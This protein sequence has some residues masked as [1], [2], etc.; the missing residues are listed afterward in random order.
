VFSERSALQAFG[1][2]WGS[3]QGLWPWLSERLALWAGERP[4]RK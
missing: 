4:Q 2:F 3:F 1:L